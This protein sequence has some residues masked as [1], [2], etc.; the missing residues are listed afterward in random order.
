MPDTELHDRMYVSLSENFARAVTVIG[1][2]AAEQC[3]AVFT[4]WARTYPCARFMVIAVA[5]DGSDAEEL[6][7]GLALPDHVFAYLPRISF[8]G[9]FTNATNLLRLLRCSMD[10]RILW[11][12]PEPEYWTDT[13]TEN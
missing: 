5:P 7:W 2:S 11:V 8:T 4:E 3:M 1:M 6:G 13:P 12:D 10:A 9:R